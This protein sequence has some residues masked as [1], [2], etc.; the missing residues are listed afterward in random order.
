MKICKGIDNA[1]HQNITKL[2]IS[3]TMKSI[4]NGIGGFADE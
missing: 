3:I 4:A 1:V 2:E